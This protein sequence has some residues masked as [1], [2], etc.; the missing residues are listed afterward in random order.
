MHFEF[1]LLDIKASNSIQDKEMATVGK[2]REAHGSVNTKSVSMVISVCL[3]LYKYTN[4][5]INTKGFLSKL[6]IIFFVGS[7][8]QVQL[9]KSM[10]F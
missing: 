5:S 3:W 2:K 6:L 7:L 4:D 9:E 1:I 8:Q 10:L